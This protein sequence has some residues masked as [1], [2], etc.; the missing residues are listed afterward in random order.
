M[1]V[2][3]WECSHFQVLITE[4]VTDLSFA[5]TQLWAIFI[6]QVQKWRALCA[7]EC[8]QHRCWNL[9]E[10]PC[11]AP[12]EH[13]A[14]VPCFAPCLHSNSA[15]GMLV[16]LLM[17]TL[18]AGTLWGWLFCKPFDNRLW[19]YASPAVSCICCCCQFG[20]NDCELYRF[21]QNNGLDLSFCSQHSSGIVQLYHR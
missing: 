17:Q 8:C 10:I 6:V 18:S 5:H 16:Q 2:L 4:G 7:F 3:L 11:S 20:L 15:A 21:A 13:R 19:F 14:L 12:A 9:P 1:N